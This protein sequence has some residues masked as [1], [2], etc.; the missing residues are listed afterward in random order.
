MT[1]I[2]FWT[3]AIYCNI[4]RCLYLR[5]EKYFLNFILHFITLDTIFNI[6]K[7]NM[8]L[9]ADVFLNWRTST[10]DELFEADRQHLYDIY[11][12]LPAQFRY[13]KSRGVICKIWGLFVN[14]LTADDKYCLLKRE[15]LLQHFQM[16]LPQKRKNLSQ[17]LF[18]MF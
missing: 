10:T 1:S 5:N 11:S 18:L 2:L 16:Q 13:K 4:F 3:E 6:F 14:L 8:N 15:N 12:S 7:K 9:I 17:F